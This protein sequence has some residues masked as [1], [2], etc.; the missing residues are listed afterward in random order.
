SCVV[1]GR[2]SLF[3]E[4]LPVAHDAHGN[5]TCVFATAAAVLDQDHDCN[6]RRARGRIPGEPSVVAVEVP[7]L[8]GVDA[9]RRDVAHL[10]G[11]G[12]TSQVH[13]GN[14]LVIGCTFLLCH[15]AFERGLDPRQMLLVRLDEATPARRKVC[16]TVPSLVSMLRTTCGWY[17]VP[18]LA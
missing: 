11:T 17:N 6:L 7:D 9:A 12:L 3:F 16:T 2:Q 18:P 13:A 1:L 14:A 8:A 5:G 4:L 15:H 10:R